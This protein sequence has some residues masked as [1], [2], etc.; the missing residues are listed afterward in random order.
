[1]AHHVEIENF[2][3]PERVEYAYGLAQRY[4][5]ERRQSLADA[6]MRAARARDPKLLKALEKGAEIVGK[7][8][9]AQMGRTRR[10]IDVPFSHTKEHTESQL[11]REAYRMVDQG[12]PIENF[13]WV[14]LAGCLVAGIV[15]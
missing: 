7:M 12:T 1:M 4:Q 8:S 10:G 13:C 6:A 2:I 11:W 9:E 5:M 3:T 15:T 14:Y